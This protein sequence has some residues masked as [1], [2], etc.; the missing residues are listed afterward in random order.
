MSDSSSYTWQQKWAAIT[1]KPFAFLSLCGSLSILTHIL[2]H[3]TRRRQV[4]HHILLGLSAYDIIHAFFM[5]LGTWPIPREMQNTTYLASGTEQTCTAQG[6]FMQLGGIA[7]PLYTVE[8]ALYYLLVGSYGWKEEKLKKFE[9]PLF[10]LLPCTV[11]IVTSLVGLL[12]YGPATLWCWQPVCAA[13]NSA[14]CINRLVYYAVYLVCMLGVIIIMTMMYSKVSAQ[15]RKIE[16]YRTNAATTAATTTGTDR[17]NNQQREK[18]KASR[19]IAN[20][21]AFWIGAFLLSYIFGFIVRL[22]ELI[23]QGSV[24]DPFWALFTIFTPSQGFLNSLVYFRPIYMSRNPDSIITACL[25]CRCG[26]WTSRFINHSI[27]VRRETNDPSDTQ[28]IGPTQQANHGNSEEEKIEETADCL[29][30]GVNRS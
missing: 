22:M 23:E 8:L 20:Q 28:E 25:T 27:G 17:S 14:A 24:P 21:A 15:E 9:L 2:T 12:S 18:I 6:F 16:K 7:V 4:R 3:P 5:F 29:E 19:Q 1:P 30:E 13:T 10:H 11:A 26:R